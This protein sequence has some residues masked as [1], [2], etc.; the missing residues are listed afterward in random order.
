[1]RSSLLALTIW[2]LGGVCNAGQPVRSLLEIRHE[3]L[4]IQQWDNSCGAAALATILTFYKRIPIT[5]EETARGMLQQ[6]NPLRV[7][8]RG[9]F[10]LLDMKRYLARIG[11][12]SDGYNNMTLIDL[13]DKT[14]VIVPLT[15]KGYHHFVVV[16][17]VTGNGVDIA[18]PSFGNYELQKAQF[19][20]R[21]AGIGFEVRSKR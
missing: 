18:D 5:E 10:S 6:T 20:A 16:R 11:F 12:D 7:R 3:G 1:M 13:A 9:G 4:I 15:T 8:A 21:W 17:A 14:P 2:L 19:S